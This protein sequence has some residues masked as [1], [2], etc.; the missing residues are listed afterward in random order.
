MGGTGIASSCKAASAIRVPP[1]G[2]VTNTWVAIGKKHGT[3]EIFFKRRAGG[4]TQDEGRCLETG[5][6]KCGPPHG[7]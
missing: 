6:T 4:Q 3:P 2:R 1:I 5:F 7:S